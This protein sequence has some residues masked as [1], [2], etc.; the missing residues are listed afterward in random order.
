MYHPKDVVTPVAP[1][2]E[3]NNSHSYTVKK[4]DNSNMVK[5]AY[6]GKFAKA[7]NTG[8]DERVISGEA[9]KWTE[10]VF[11]FSSTKIS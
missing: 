8:E 3:D 7:H 9:N 6:I 10:M 4:N 1:H 11:D 5:G 2:V